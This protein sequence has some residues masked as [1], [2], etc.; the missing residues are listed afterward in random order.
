MPQII[1]LTL[2]VI[3]GTRGVET[4][5][6]FTKAEHGWNASTWHLYSHSGTHMDAQVHFEAGP[7]TIDETP[8]ETCMGPAWVIKILPCE[9]QRLITVADLGEV[10]TKFQPGE[11]LIFQTGWSAHVNNRDIYRDQMPRISEELARW[12][13]AHQVRLLGVEPPSIADV[14]NLPEVTLIHDILL[15]GKINIVEGLTNLDQLKSIRVLFG[16]MPLK[17]ARSDGSPVRAFAIEGVDPH[18][19]A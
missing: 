2:P 8:L 13:V 9:P 6:A 15:A 16:A 18:L 17:L 14:N 10:A 5:P 19:F 4:E 11:S 3:P 7:G 1:D 12:I